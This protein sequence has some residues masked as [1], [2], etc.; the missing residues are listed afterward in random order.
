MTGPVPVTQLLRELVL[1]TRPAHRCLLQ[2]GLRV[3][4]KGVAG[5]LAGEQ[6]EALARDQPEQGIAR[7][8]DAAGD[9]DR[10]VTTELRAIDLRM[11]DKGGAVALVEKAP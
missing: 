1:Q 2:K 3:G 7:N 4:G 5:L 9:I 10:V 6:I 8:R 11:G